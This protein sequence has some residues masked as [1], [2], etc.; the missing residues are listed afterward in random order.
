MC[1]RFTIRKP[2]TIPGELRPDVVEADLSRAR[3]NV[4]PTQKIPVLFI[5]DHQRVLAD[6]RWG[7]IPSWT[8]DPAIGNRLINARAETL[9]DK[10]SFRRAFRSQRCLIPADGFYEWQA[11]DK[12]RQ[13]IYIQ[14]QQGE[15]FTLAGL[16]EIW[17]PQ[18]RDPLR[19]CTI[20][21][22]APNDLI[23]PIHDRMPVILPAACR[24]SWLDPQLT[25]VIELSKMLQP[26]D[27]AK[28][29]AY[30]VTRHVNSP[31]NDDQRCIDPA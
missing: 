5:R 4:A 16:Y 31:A 7:L 30:P 14:V 20:I 29:N 8:D 17:Q 22:T 26:F 1:A 28:M 3:Y 6:F 27:A 18:G 19:T 10:P 9:A 2:K 25:D 11:T 23:R 13:P 15:L 24:D 21:T 12:G